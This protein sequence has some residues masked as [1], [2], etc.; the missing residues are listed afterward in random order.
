MPCADAAG[1]PPA[2]LAYPPVAS[3]MR[4]TAQ[5]SLWW[6]CHSCHGSK[7]RRE[8]Q[9]QHL[10]PPVADLSSDTA[11]ADIQDWFKNLGLLLTLPPGGSL[12]LAVL[13]CGVRYAHRMLGYLH[14]LSAADQDRPPLLRGAL[15]CWDEAAVDGCDAADLAASLDSL[16]TYLRKHNPAVQRYLTMAEQQWG[17]AQD[18]SAP[19]QQQQQQQQQH[20]GVPVLGA[21][22]IRDG[23]A[24]VQ[25]RD[26]RMR[27]NAEPYTTPL[28]AAMDWDGQHTGEDHRPGIMFSF[29]DVQERGHATPQPVTGTASGYSSRHKLSLDNALFP[30]LHPG[31]VGAFRTGASLSTLLKQRMQQLF[32]PF[33][34][35]KEYL[36]VMFQVEAVATL[37]GGVSETA[38]FSC[39]QREKQL[40]PDADPADII[41]AVAR[42]LVPATVPGSPAYHRNKLQDLLAMVN[43]HGIPSLFLTLTADEQTALR[44]REVE[45]MEAMA[46][47]F[48]GED[49]TW[50]DMPVEMARLFTDRVETFMA[51]HVLSARSPIL[52]RVN[53]YVTRFEAQHRGSLHAHIL[54]WVDPA[55]LPRVS[56]EIT[57]T[58][59]RYK[60]VTATDGT[61]THKPH[62]DPSDTVANAL[63][64]QE[65]TH[66]ELDVV[67]RQ[68]ADPG[69]AEFLGGV[70]STRPT[71]QQLQEALGG[72]WGHSAGS[73]ASLL[74]INTT[75]LC[76]HNRDVRRHNVQ[77]LKWHHANNPA[78]SGPVYRV[79]MQHDAHRHRH[80]QPW[81]AKPGFH[82]LT[83]VA[84]GCRVVYTS[85]VCKTTGATNSALGTV[86]EVV[87]GP[88]PPCADPGQPWVQA[89]KVRLDLGGRLV[90]VTRS[91]QRTTRRQDQ[92]FTKAT[93]PLL[94]GYAITAHRA[95]GAT[96]AGRTIVHVRKAFAPGM[97]YVMLSRVTTRDNLY[98]IGQL[99]P[100]D[101]VPATAAAF[102][103]EGDA[104]VDGSSSSSS[105]SSSED[106]DSD[107]VDTSGDESS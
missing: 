106:S 69:L 18:T 40:S 100:A 62:L 2:A 103:P 48:T 15:V 76:T 53:H 98:I 27:S 17:T 1:A 74:D 50:R 35:V 59:C 101:F 55:D 81:L 88:P 93:F 25:G 42:Q 56:Q 43:R 12:Q 82:L 57:A 41:K 51:R 105:S 45:Q 99:Q 78:V 39:I 14:A 52:G 67:Y 44:W 8:H 38:L 91:V 58:K 34:M 89:L 26:P 31:G 68:S 23:V 73:I 80:M 64:F 49:I 86:E 92:D 85:T 19:Q 54:L 13:R 3:L 71:Q 96:L 84:Q 46:K 87:L 63:A 10:Q 65:A 4:A 29:G 24:D 6:A 16:I 5:S 32:S 95:Q 104:G 22:C 102:P 72:C 90:T 33:T 77:A 28:T 61:V 36:L 47:Q 21:D 94:L 11:A 83:N 60:A 20:G 30:F 75:V 97:V 79:D 70:R 107:L 7:T 37:V 9:A 66:I